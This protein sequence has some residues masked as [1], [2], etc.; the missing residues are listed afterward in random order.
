MRFAREW[1]SSTGLNWNT[2]ESL[3]TYVVHRLEGTTKWPVFR[4]TWKTSTAAAYL[5]RIPSHLRFL[6]VDFPD[7][8][9]SA[10]IRAGLHRVF[11]GGEVVHRQ[12]MEYSQLHKLLL[13]LRVD[14]SATWASTGAAVAFFCMLRASEVQKLDASKASC[15][16]VKGRSG[17]TAGFHFKFHDKTHI[18]DFRGVLFTSKKLWS[19]EYT[20]LA[21]VIQRAQ[22]ASLKLPAGTRLQLFNASIANT[23]T[24]AANAAIGLGMGSF[25]PGGLMFHLE[26]GTPSEPY[27]Q[28]GRL[29]TTVRNSH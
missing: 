28:N 27:C 14:S 1:H 21:D 9:A 8:R 10:R 11:P 5:G 4:K 15:I 6:G 12:A 23:I 26:T 3:V 24:K 20:F 19:V 2:D 18:E 22:L 16:T 13:T 29:V 17:E 25:R 7:V